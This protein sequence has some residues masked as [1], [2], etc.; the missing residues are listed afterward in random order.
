MC[1]IQLSSQIRAFLG[2]GQLKAFASKAW[3]CDRVCLESRRMKHESISAQGSFAQ[4]NV[5]RQAESFDSDWIHL[6]ILWGCI[7]PCLF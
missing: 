2:R 6:K 5:A 1:L 4:H 3:S 7:L